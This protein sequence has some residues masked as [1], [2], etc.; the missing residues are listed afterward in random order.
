M[1]E[2]MTLPDDAEQVRLLI[3]A[4]REMTADRDSWIRQ[5]D[6]ARE[7]ALQQADEVIALRQTVT[8]LTRALEQARAALE[9]TA[10]QA[11]LCANHTALT[12][13]PHQR[14]WLVAEVRREARAGIKAIA[15][16]LT[17]AQDHRTTTTEEAG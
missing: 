13:W 5:T 2:P 11:S 16:A 15:A 14:D 4:L 1:S 8:R 12:S 3:G 7:L 9:D 10:A 17:A 6:D